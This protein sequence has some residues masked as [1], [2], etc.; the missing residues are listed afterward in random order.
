MIGF[1]VYGNRKEQF[2]D[3]IVRSYERS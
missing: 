1:G 2:A 3:L